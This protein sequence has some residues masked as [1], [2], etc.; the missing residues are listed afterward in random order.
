MSGSIAAATVGI[1]G[2]IIDGTSMFVNFLVEN[3]YPVMVGIV[4]GVGSVTGDVY[5]IVR[6]FEPVVESDGNVTAVSTASIGIPT[7]ADSYT[8]SKEEFADS[9][10]LFVWT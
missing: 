7:H 1:V 9:A 3:A 10:F 2:A 8:A 5:G 4:L 6:I